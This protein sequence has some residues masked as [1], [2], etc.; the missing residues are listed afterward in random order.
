MAEIP[1]YFSDPERACPATTLYRSVQ[2]HGRLEAVDDAGEKA[3]ALQAL[4]E[5]FQ[6]E[7][8]HAPITADDERYRSAVRGLLIARVRLDD[9]DGKSKLAQNRS[10]DEPRALLEKL[11]A[12][13]RDGDARAIEL[14]RA[15]N[16]DTPSPKFLDGP[17]GVKLFCALDPR[18]GLEAAALLSGNYWTGAFP[19]ERIARA[20][21]GSAAW[22]GARDERG[23]LVATARA[24]S[25]GARHGWIYDVVV[26]PEQQGRGLGRA[27]V[28]LLLDHPKLR[29]CWQIHLKT[30]DAQS[31]YEKFGFVARGPSA[32]FTQ[33]VLERPF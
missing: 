32:P 31:L 1:S 12:R 3:R 8:G 15:A 13:G 20:H 27:L 28:R 11:W 4:M 30:R 19:V 21:A 14:I 29:G 25:D 22:V 2:V 26:A 5:K 6:P 18:A 9:V 23:R 33:M 7:G 17:P 10:P 24:N 16:P